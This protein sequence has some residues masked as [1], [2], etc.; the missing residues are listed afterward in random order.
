MT[1]ENA[2]DNFFKQYPPSARASVEADI[3]YQQAKRVDNL[4]RAAEITCEILEGSAKTTAEGRRIRKN[5]QEFL[6]LCKIFES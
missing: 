5:N 6:K 2:M 3:S 4:S 1:F